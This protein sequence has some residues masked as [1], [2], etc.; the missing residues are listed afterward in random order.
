M[1][2]QSFLITGAS[3]GIGAVYADRLARRGHDLILV[4]R[5]A[6]KLAALADQ[7]RSDNGVSV[8]IIA[9][10][11]AKPD[12]LARVEAR[13]R[14]DE[15]ITGLINNAGIA[16][17]S[18]FVEADPAFLGGMID[19]N[20]VAV[21]RLSAAIAP[22][23]AAKGAG[24]IVNITSVTALMPDS[25]TAVYPAS[26]AYV[27]AFTEALQVE[28][29][30]K[31]V[32][33]QAVVPGITRTPIWDE[34]QLANIPAEMVMDVND[35]VDAALAGFDQGE[36]VTIPALPDMADY[37]VYIAARSALRPNLSLARP[38]PRYL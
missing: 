20:I 10:D 6:D 26:K 12:D 25:F 15:A 17:E 9:A 36:T 22:R 38:A 11:L 30:A 28:L 8:D 24:A 1:T 3:D 34:A 5:R 31:G 16:G 7:L 13:L 4:A 35:M 37:D 19:L 14:T 32:R 29:G 27:L 23:L 2:K 18:S 33:I 21:T